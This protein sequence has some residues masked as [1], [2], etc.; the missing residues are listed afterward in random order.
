MMQP[1]RDGTRAIRGEGDMSD[2]IWTRLSEVIPEPVRWL[3]EGRIPLGKVTLLDGDPGVGKSTLAMELAA[4]VTNGSAMPL[5][6]GPPRGPADVVIFSGDD[7]LAD[8]V[9]PRLKAA[10]ADLS[11]IRP[12][13]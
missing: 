1:R 3:W 11:R 12:V 4:R 10:G 9:L 7:G 6:K 13:E 8:T 2:P 5:V